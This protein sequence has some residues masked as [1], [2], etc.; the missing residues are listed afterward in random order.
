MLSSIIEYTLRSTALIAIVWLVLKIL[1]VRSPWLERSAWRATLAASL[2]MPVLMKLTAPPPHDMPEL[3]WLQQIYTVAAGPA[4]AAFSWQSAVLWIVAIVAVGLLARHSVGVARWWNVRR[5]ATPLTRPMFANLD[6]RATEQVQSPATAFSTVLVPADFEAWPIET[7]QLVIAHER[8]H[9]LHKDFYVQWLAQA[10]R[11]LFWFNPLAGWLA[12]RLSLLSEHISDESAL[13][14]I[15]QRAEYAKLLLSFASRTV[16]SEQVVAMARSRSLAARI[17]R[18]LAEVRTQRTQTW[19]V[20]LFVVTLVPVFMII[21]SFQPVAAR[22]SDRLQQFMRAMP[23]AS[24]L[25]L[26]ETTG[27]AGQVVLPRSN[28]QLPLTQPIYPHASRRLKQEGTVVVELLVL[29]DGSVG[30]ARIARSSGHPELDYSA[31]YEVFNWKVN[32][33]TVNGLPTR[34]WGRFAITFK[35]SNDERPP[36]G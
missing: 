19:K 15:D 22:S 24:R 8:A 16:H 5:H 12:R 2:A 34:M 27:A 17:D 30:D 28:P 7:Q 31:F 18:V 26:E 23:G 10:Y 9:V 35:L 1:R 21:G 14:E 36:P 33:G 20:L 6:V 3:I 4:K 29:E 25:N 13:D 11:C 32:P